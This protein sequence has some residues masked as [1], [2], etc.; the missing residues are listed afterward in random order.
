MGAAL[1]PMMLVAGLAGSAVNAFGT[2]RGMEAQ[3]AEAAYRSQVAAN[4]A[5]IARQ[6]AGLETESGEIRAANQEMKVRS[7]V[8]Q[9]KS[10][11]AASTSNC[12]AS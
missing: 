1:A 3:S 8:G 7:M 2:Y 5:A 12:S 9:T 4:N 6:N 11:Q 10:E